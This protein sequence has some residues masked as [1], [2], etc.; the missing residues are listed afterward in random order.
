VSQALHHLVR[1]FSALR[2]FVFVYGVLTVSA[3][4]TV[5]TRSLIAIYSARTQSKH[6][7]SDK[8][9]VSTGGWYSVVGNSFHQAKLVITASK[10]LI[11]CSQCDMCT[12]RHA[13]Q[14]QR[15]LAMVAVIA[16]RPDKLYKLSQQAALTHIVQS[17][18]SHANTTVKSMQRCHQVNKTS[19][20]V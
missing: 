14:V 6:H 9:A 5:F 20:V 12:P 3:I 8:H 13:V 7:N 18:A 15:S 10:L 19:A 4:C 11:V 17:F 2:Q 16:H 1:L